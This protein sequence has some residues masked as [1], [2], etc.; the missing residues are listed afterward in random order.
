MDSGS[1]LFINLI[2]SKIILLVSSI[3]GQPQI[4]IQQDFSPL[5][6]REK[7]VWYVHLAALIPAWIVFYLLDI[8]IFGILWLSVCV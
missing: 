2:A 1:K 5:S 7:N 3:F 4:L 6:D 8:Y